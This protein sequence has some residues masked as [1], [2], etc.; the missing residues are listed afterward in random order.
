MSKKRRPQNVKH[1]IASFNQ[2]NRFKFSQFIF[3]SILNHPLK[4][5]VKIFIIKREMRIL[6]ADIKYRMLIELTSKSF[7]YEIRDKR[8]NEIYIT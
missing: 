7:T 6:I 4:F 2:A 5:L 3:H 1:Y 8:L